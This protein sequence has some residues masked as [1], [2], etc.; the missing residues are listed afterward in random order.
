MITHILRKGLGNIP[1]GFEFRDDLIGCL[2]LVLTV[3]TSRCSPLA[4][5]YQVYMRV[6]VV[7]L[8]IQTDRYLKSRYN[9]IELG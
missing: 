8:L 9:Y 7:C 6:Y 1:P 3:L 2:Y 5:A 4:D